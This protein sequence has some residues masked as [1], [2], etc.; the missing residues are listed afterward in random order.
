MWVPQAWCCPGALPQPACAC[1]R[2][3]W[4]LLPGGAAGLTARRAAHARV[5]ALLLQELAE[6]CNAN[7]D[8]KGFV[9]L[10]HGLDFRSS[11]SRWDAVP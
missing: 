2:S 6:L 8:C 3:P 7:V 11:V 5:R 1:M 10:P 4:R 9:Y